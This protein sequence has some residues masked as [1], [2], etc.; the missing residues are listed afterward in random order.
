MALLLF[1]CCSLWLVGS[2]YN[3]IL[4]IRWS[5]HLLMSSTKGIKKQ[6][7]SS[8][9][10]DAVERVTYLLWC[11]VKVGHSEARSA[12]KEESLHGRSCLTRVINMTSIYSA[13]SFP[14]IFI[15]IS[16][17]W[18]R[19][20]ITIGTTAMMIIS[21]DCSKQQQSVTVR[22]IVIDHDH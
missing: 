21:K 10:V 14:T 18:Q 19:F 11:L 13:K 22:H 16:V 20:C 5:Q 6:L 9:S 3:L 12:E 17:S 8:V 1:C 2:G 15:K 4:F 7:S